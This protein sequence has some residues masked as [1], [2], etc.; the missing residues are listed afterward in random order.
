M[1]PAQRDALTSYVALLRGINLGAKNKV[2]MPALRSVVESLGHEDVRTYIQSGNVLFRSRSR[3]V[4]TIAAA[5][6]KSITE[7]FGFRVAVVVRS[8][9]E[10]RQVTTSNP[11]LVAGADPSA[12]HVVLLGSSPT[13]ASVGA[14]DP[15]RSPPDEFAVRHAEVYLHC[16]NGFGRSKLSLD[17][18]E[19]TLGAPGTIRNWKTVTKLLELMASPP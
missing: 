12:L 4:P 18:F 15:D 14:L 11:F 8:Q 1:S 9:P 3:G 10:L 17:Y 7:E 19:R 6:E 5:L 13:K 16:P 2:P